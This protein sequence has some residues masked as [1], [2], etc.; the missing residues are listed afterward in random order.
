MNSYA[1]DKRAS[2][3]EVQMGD[4]AAADK[5]REGD[6]TPLFFENEYR[7]RWFV[8]VCRPPGT[9]A[10]RPG[11]EGVCGLVKTKINILRFSAT[12]R[13]GIDTV[14]LGRR[15]P[16]RGVRQSVQTTTLD[17]VAKPD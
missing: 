15:R 4:F 3:E 13:A 16:G 6:P 10:G 12:S 7:L 9:G 14:V 8:G 11:G 17:V 5:R 1:L 2:C